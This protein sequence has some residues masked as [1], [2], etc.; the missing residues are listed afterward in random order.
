M[1]C[2]A[3][4]SRYSLSTTTR[5]VWSTGIHLCGINPL[6]QELLQG[7]HLTTAALGGAACV[8]VRVEGP[9]QLQGA[10]V[11]GPRGLLDGAT[12]AAGP[13]LLVQTQAELSAAL[14]LRPAEA[15]V[16]R[17]WFKVVSIIRM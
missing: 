12:A 5:H 17:P 7:Q 4:R 9:A 1:H 16:Q 6:I 10:L 13:H 14:A 3:Y 15:A 8:S 2:S 11:G